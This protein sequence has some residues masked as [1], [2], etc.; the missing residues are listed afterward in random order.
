[1]NKVIFDEKSH[2]YWLNGSRLISGTQVYR[3]FSKPY[4]E[5]YW[6]SYKAIQSILGEKKFKEQKKIMFKGQV[7]PKI[8]D[9]IMLMLPPDSLEKYSVER[10]KFKIDWEKERVRAS[11][12]GTAFHKEREDEDIKNGFAI[13][14]FTEETVKVVSWEK[15]HDNE[16][17]PGGLKEMPDGY[18]PEALLFDEEYMVA[19]Q[20]DR[21]FIKTIDDI[22]YFYL[23]DYKSNKEK[24]V[25]KSWGF[26]NCL[27]PISHLV[28]CKYN[29]YA[30]QSSVY[31]YMLERQG[32]VQAGAAITHVTDYDVEKMELIKMPYY[33]E[34]VINM[35]DMIKKM[36]IIELIQ[37]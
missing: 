37:E 36:N 34:E 12:M 11:T 16:S 24:P 15:K 19:G 8:E 35:F 33:K 18:Y 3:L 29:A 23:D 21:L 10:Q 31:S 20:A 1:M 32:F 26:S 9:M 2:K 14:P 17:Y 4:N 6:L 13:N 28:D 27:E 22:R 7:S 25:F 30:I 5:E